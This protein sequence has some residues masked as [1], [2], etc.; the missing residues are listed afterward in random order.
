MSDGLSSSMFWAGALLAFTPIVV[1]GIAVLLWWYT[2]KR[3]R[4]GVAG[5]GAPPTGPDR[6]GQGQDGD[7]HRGT[8]ERERAPR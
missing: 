3:Q 1:G 4:P 7:A 6:E 8:G 5:S 2:F